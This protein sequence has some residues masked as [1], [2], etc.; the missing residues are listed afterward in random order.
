MEDLFSKIAGISKAQ[1]DAAKEMEGPWGNGPVTMAEP[2]ALAIDT[3]IA[4]LDAT[5][6]EAR[7]NITRAKAAKDTLLARKGLIEL[8]P[9]TQNQP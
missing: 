3:Q 7:A 2:E 9:Q 1:V 4:E 5:I 6:L 8:S